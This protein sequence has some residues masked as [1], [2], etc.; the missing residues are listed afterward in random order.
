MSAK[1]TSKRVTYDGK[2]ITFITLNTQTDWE[3]YQDPGEEAKVL[4]GRSSMY[5]EKPDG[6]REITCHY[7]FGLKGKQVLYIYCSQ[8]AVCY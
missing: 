3:W 1:E 4:T 8:L 2:E 7:F 6:L 5:C